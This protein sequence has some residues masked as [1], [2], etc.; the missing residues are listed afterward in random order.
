[1]RRGLFIL[2]SCVSVLIIGLGTRASGDTG[3]TGGTGASP[4][5]DA[6]IGAPPPDAST[7]CWFTVS[8][9][10]TS[11]A[12]WG[13]TSSGVCTIDFFRDATKSQVRMFVIK[14]MSPELRSV[15]VS[16]RFVGGPM[17]GVDSPAS[18]GPFVGDAT[19]IGWNRVE[20]IARTQMQGTFRV[21]LTTIQ[22][23]EIHGSLEIDLPLS[24]LPTHAGH[25]LR[26]LTLRASF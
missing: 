15:K 23:D 5:H 20:W 10:V 8:G 12:T 1:M 11:R 3:G 25:P 24:N 14:G 4:H 7:S 21:D 16:L 13:A 22:P 9:G 6:S 2:G 19:V 26:L 18:M 17:S